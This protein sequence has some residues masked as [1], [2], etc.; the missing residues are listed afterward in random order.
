M[1][2]GVA[3][4]GSSTLTGIGTMVGSVRYMSPEQMMGERVD[5]RADVFSLAAVAYEL[6]TGCPPFP[7]KT[8]TEGVARVVHGDHVPP[9]QADR[10]LPAA[11]NAAFVRAFATSPADRYPDT[12]AFGR[13]LPAHSR[14]P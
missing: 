6:L 14:P 11:V 4:L 9:R 10:R 12:L 5:G 7:G 1:D 2:F 8:I 13:S 3:G